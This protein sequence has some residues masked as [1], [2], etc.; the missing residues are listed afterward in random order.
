MPL[1]YVLTTGNAQR[2]SEASGSHTNRMVRVGTCFPTKWDC[3]IHEIPSAPFQTEICPAFWT[4]P[5]MVVPTF[6]IHGRLE[7]VVS[8]IAGK[9]ANVIQIEGEVP[10]P[11]IKTKQRQSLGLVGSTVS[12]ITR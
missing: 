8:H 12:G 4:Q 2:S 5:Y 11:K 7:V 9:I 10:D 6:V 1:I 3:I